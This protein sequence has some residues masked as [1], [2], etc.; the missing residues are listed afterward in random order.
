MLKIRDIMSSIAY[1]GSPRQTIREAAQAFITHTLGEIPVINADG[2]LSGIIGPTQ[3]MR[4]IDRNL[5]FDN[6]IEKIMIRD[7]V[8]TTPDAEWDSIDPAWTHIIPV[9]EKGRIVGVVVPPGDPG[10]QNLFQFIHS[11]P[12]P[13]LLNSTHDS[14]VIIN[15]NKQIVLFNKGAERIFA[16]GQEMVLGKDYLEVFPEGCL[17]EVLE[18]QKSAVQHKRTYQGKTYVSLSSP[19]FSGGK[20]M[21]A[22]EALQDISHIENISHELEYTKKLKEEMDAIIE[23]SFDS[24]FV[25]DATGQV[26]SLNEAY[27][28]ITG[29]QA[30]DII[31]KNMYDLVEQGLYDRSATTMVIETHRP[32]TF[33]QK[34]KTGKTLLVTGNPIFDEEGKLVR[35]L[36]NGRDITELN[37]L[38]QEVEQAYS[39]SK[40]YEEELKRATMASREM[41]IYSEKSKEVFDLIVRVAKVDSTVLVYG[42]SGVGKELIMRELHN[43]SPRKNK[44]FLSINCAAIPE[45]LLE[46]ELF[47][48][49][50]GAFSG[51]RK[52]GKMGIF[53]LANGGTL[54]LDEIGELPL[55]LQAKLL[56]VIQ[57]KEISRI[58]G[59]ASIHVDV[60]IIT[61]TNRDLWDMVTKRQFREDLYYR[62]HVVPISVPPLRERKEEIPALVFHFLKTFNEKYGMNKVLDEKLM[63]AFMDYHWPG[64]V[65][66]LRNVIERAVVTSSEAVITAI[67]LEGHNEEVSG[68]YLGT[69]DHLPNIELREKVALYEKKLIQQYVDI[70]KTSRKA[71][72]ALGVSQTTIVRKA[73][74]YGIDL[75]SK[76]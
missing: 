25:T 6:P 57:E 26:L 46:S 3:L 40:H 49:N 48:Y 58:G 21:G 31:G 15:L 75:G 50:S 45:S 28:R 74:Q 37:R 62:L 38:K 2:S 44:P 17:H 36:T 14:L 13:C 71:A 7:V 43:N 12:I 20:L 55:N 18:T 5:D 64:N 63:A 54:C 10:E 69:K 65:R 73:G 51:A 16:L 61:A 52:E 29:I 76:Q 32:V 22:I 60:R 11:A 23:A 27:T 4:A 67:K 59:T 19:I 41:V 66:E 30:E 35:V 56:R 1:A 8:V 72:E 34:I 53:E 9:V 24:I 39:L 33:T 42:E 70:Y 47:G 68:E